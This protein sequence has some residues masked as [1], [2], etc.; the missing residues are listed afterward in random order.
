MQP[1]QSFGAALQAWS[2]GENQRA[3]VEWYSLKPV[4]IVRGGGVLYQ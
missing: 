1:W 3:W 2:P 4:Y